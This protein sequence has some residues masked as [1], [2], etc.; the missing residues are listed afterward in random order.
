[1]RSRLEDIIP[2]QDIAPDSGTRLYKTPKL[3]AMRLPVSYN[4]GKASR[5]GYRRFH[6]RLRCSGHCDVKARSILHNIRPIR[7][8]ECAVEIRRFF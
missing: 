2:D 3:R 7:P 5:K 6:D 1:M 8:E 4:L